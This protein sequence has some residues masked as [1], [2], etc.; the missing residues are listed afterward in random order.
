APEGQPVVPPADHH[1][2]VAVAGAIML[3][4]TRFAPER[5]ETRFASFLAAARDIAAGGAGRIPAEEP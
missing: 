4:A 5:A 1:T 2:G 3:A